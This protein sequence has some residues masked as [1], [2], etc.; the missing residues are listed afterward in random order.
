M[1]Y[2]SYKINGLEPTTGSA[3]SVGLADLSDVSG[4]FLNGDFVAYDAS[5]SSFAP[6]SVANDA[7]AL[8][9][10]GESDAYSNSG[11][12]IVTGGTWG[13]YDSAPITCTGVTFNLQGATNW[14]SSITLGA[15]KWLI[16][17]QTA[18]VFSGTGYLAV[19]IYSG[20]TVVGSTGVIGASLTTYAGNSTLT[21]SSLS[22][23]SSTTIRFNI[24]GLQN[25]ASAAS[26]GNTPAAGGWVLVQRLS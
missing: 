17:A 22:L 3:F 12:S 20:T 24:Q 18:A 7:I 8:F 15:G 1:S 13:F 10:Q 23:T 2:N 21:K 14:L 6:A 4:T 25:V 5:T 9:G 16:E 26:Q 19:N 11:L